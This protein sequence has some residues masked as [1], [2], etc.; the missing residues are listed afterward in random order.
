MSTVI[1]TSYKITHQPTEEEPYVELDC[2]TDAS[3]QW[4][5]VVYQETEIT[6]ENAEPCSADL[7][8]SSY[9]ENGWL[10][11][12]QYRYNEG[13]STL[14]GFNID[15]KA[16]D[17]LIVETTDEDADYSMNLSNDRTDESVYIY[18]SED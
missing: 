16:G 12:E 4:C 14:Y 6:D 15:L 2:D 9:T 17:I 18:P 5:E 11:A 7:S 1:D 13:D 8:N 10:F 3:Y